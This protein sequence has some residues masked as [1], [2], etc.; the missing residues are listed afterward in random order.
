MF[1]SFHLG[2]EYLDLLALGGRDS[3]GEIF[4]WEMDFVTGNTIN[5]NFGGGCMVGIFGHKD[6][7]TGEIITL[8]YIYDPDVRPITVAEALVAIISSLAYYFCCCCFPC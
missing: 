3:N 6:V 2:P 8:G 5:Y 7:E 1:D 4:E